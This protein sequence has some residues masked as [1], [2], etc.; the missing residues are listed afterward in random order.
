M[1][2]LADYFLADYDPA[3]PKTEVSYTLLTST[4]MFGS[5]AFL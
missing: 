3:H 2:N 5:E 4:R 1:H